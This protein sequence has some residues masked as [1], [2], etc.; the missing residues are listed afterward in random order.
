VLRQA[1]SAIGSSGLGR[2]DM[3]V[4]SAWDAIMWWERRRIP[5]NAIVGAA[6][7]LTG[8]SM[9]MLLLLFALV[10]HIPWDIP[11][12]PIFVGFGVLLYGFAANVCYTLGW[13]TELLVRAVSPTRADRYAL[14]AFTSGIALS[15]G[16]TLLPILPWTV[17]LTMSATQHSR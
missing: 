11:D 1:L 2:R 13:V 4:R 15:V 7:V 12:P 10:F 3:A 17:I 14:R 6:G 8:V 16:L 5:F 9:T